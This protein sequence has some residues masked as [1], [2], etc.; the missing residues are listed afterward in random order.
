LKQGGGARKE[1]K[2]RG[3]HAP[4]NTE[5]LHSQEHRESCALQN[6]EQFVSLQIVT[7]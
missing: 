5:S 6:V 2:E 4:F 7:L 1:K 3:I